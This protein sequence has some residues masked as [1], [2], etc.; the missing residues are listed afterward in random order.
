MANSPLSSVCGRTRLTKRRLYS[1]LFRFGPLG[2]QGLRS[3]DVIHLRAFV[4][5]AQQDDQQLSALNVINPVP[6]AKINLHFDHASANASR[7]AGVSLLQP[8]NSVKNHCATL[9]VPEAAQPDREF[10]G[11]TYLHST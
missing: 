5:A 10:F 4:A 3:L 1:S 6:W 11:A 8:L 7:L 9:F 2:R